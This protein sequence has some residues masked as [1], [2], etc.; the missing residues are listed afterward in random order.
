MHGEPHYAPDPDSRK[1]H[2]I[3]VDFRNAVATA[4]TSARQVAAVSVVALMV[5]TAVS[6]TPIGDGYAMTKADRDM[7]AIVVENIDFM[8][9]QI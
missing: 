6:C 5:L 1:S 9:A 2:I 4:I 7:R 3:H 8:I